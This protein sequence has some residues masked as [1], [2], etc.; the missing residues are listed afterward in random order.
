MKNQKPVNEPPFPVGDVIKQV[1]ALLNISMAN[2][3][4]IFIRMGYDYAIRFTMQQE[5]SAG[6][7]T[8]NGGYWAWYK[9]EWLLREEL[10]LNEFKQYA[11]VNGHNEMF[12]MWLD[13]HTPEGMKST[14][15]GNVI[16]EAQKQMLADVQ[17]VKE[18]LLKS[19]KQ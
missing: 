14:P 17:R 16:D 10:F 13:H 6:Y 18:E 11:G 4:G 19:I 15:P 3:S 1:C 9:K 12:D 7:L 8:N 5:W 2:H